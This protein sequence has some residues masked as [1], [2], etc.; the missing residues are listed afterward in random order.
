MEIKEEKQTRHNFLT[1]FIVLLTVDAEGHNMRITNLYLYSYKAT[2]LFVGQS[3]K[4]V[5]KKGLT[6]KE[7]KNFCFS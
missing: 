1:I 7:D 3:E 6:A 5:Q 2:T 4:D